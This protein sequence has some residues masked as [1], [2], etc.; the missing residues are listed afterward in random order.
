MKIIILDGYTEN[1]GDLSWEPLERF[2]ELTV[3]D[4]TDVQDTALIQ[5]RIEDAQ[6]VITNK[7]PLD[8]STLFSCPSI[9]LICM[10]ATGYDVVD[11]KAARDRNIPVCNVPG[12]GTASVSQFAIA[13]LLELCSYVALHSEAVHKGLWENNPDWCFWEKPLI[14]LSGK[15]MG[16]IGFGRIG[17][18][19]GRI[20][21]AM[22]MKVLAYD[23]F[24]S[25]S[26][27]EIAEYCEIDTLLASSDV[28]ILHCPLLPETRGI[29]RN[30]TI[31]RMKDGVL[32]VNN[33]RGPL[34]VEEDLALA[35]YS[36]K[37][38]AAA[39]DVV[40]VEPICGENPLLQAPNCI[41]TPHISWAS[42]ESRQ[43]ILDCT[44]QN[45]AAFQNGAP[46]NVVN[47]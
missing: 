14:E 4:R 5:K 24:Q 3:Y 11:I 38:A 35:L 47:I 34:V 13:L 25:E 37:V 30:E 26:G 23:T 44:I 33:S 9:R 20:G 1:P 31:A 2:G 10:L 45:I 27:R 8:S 43:R 19:T 32:L 36:G 6:I 15:T 41:I 12:Y 16:I 7:T 42:K 22:G 39:V 18:A 29:I 46:Q 28:I 21:R 40:S 17:Q